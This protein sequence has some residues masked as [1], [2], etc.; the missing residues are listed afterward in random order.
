MAFWPGLVYG[1]SV[2]ATLY[3]AYG[4]NLSQDQMAH[5]CPDARVVEKGFV[6]GFRLV[7]AGHSPRWGGGVATLVPTP[8]CRVQ[9]LIYNVLASDLDRLDRYEGHPTRYRRERL[10]VHR[11]NGSLCV[12]HVYL[13]PEP[14]EA[15][16]TQAYVEVIR[17]SYLG[18]GFD[19]APIDVAVSE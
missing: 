16:P 17:Q 7:F 5:R 14:V 8:G 12:A 2:G 19:P 18:L 1:S 10:E 11:Q 9:G 13:K 3:F 6:E 4:S 15:P